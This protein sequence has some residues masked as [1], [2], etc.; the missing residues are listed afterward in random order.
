MS[1]DARLQLMKQRPNRQLALYFR[2]LCTTWIA[3]SN[4]EAA[5]C[6]RTYADIPRR[7]ASRTYRTSECMVRR[8]N[9][10]FGSFLRNWRAGSIPFK[11]GIEMSII[12]MSGSSGAAQLQAPAHPQPSPP[13]PRGRRGELGFPP[14]P[15]HDH[16]PIVRVA[17]WYRWEG[18]DGL[19]PRTALSGGAAKVPT[20]LYSPEK[21]RDQLGP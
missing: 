16:R 5:E 11:T 10:V 20:R 2:P 19:N 7:R 3:K 8:I 12:T 9:L 6:F 21:L 13:V 18:N 17:S 4:S 14:S 1:F 15:G